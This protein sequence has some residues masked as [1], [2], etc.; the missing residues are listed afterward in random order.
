MMLI[1][2]HIFEK[3]DYTDAP[4]TP[5][6]YEYCTFINCDFL[7]STLAGVRFLD[8]QFQHCDLSLARLDGTV[9]REI[10][11]EDCK[12]LGLSFDTCNPFGL[13]VKFVNCILDHSSFYKQSFRKTIFENCRLREADFVEAD[14]TEVVFQNC[15]L[16]G[17]K[18]E[19]TILKKTDFRTSANYSIHPGL[20]ELKGA[21]FS[22]TGLPGLLQHTGIDIS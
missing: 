14:L 3:A 12:M 22:L 19:R 9:F 11:F 1:E 5:G 4:L 10:L 8:C 2:D 15:D 16:T 13:K 17:A 20:N 7:K 18:F 21:K 6:D